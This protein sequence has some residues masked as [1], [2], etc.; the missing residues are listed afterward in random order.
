MAAQGS[1]HSDGPQRG[2]VARTVDLLRLIAESAGNASG[3]ELAEAAQLP[4]PSVHRLLALLIE[5]GMV[6]QDPTTKRYAP[7]IEF[8]RQAALVLRDRDIAE[9]ARP[10][11]ERLVGE[12]EEA[13][14]LGQYIG[15]GRMMFVGEVPS[16]DPLGYRIEKYVPTSVAWGASGRSI[17]AQLDDGTIGTVVRR[18]DRAPSTAAAM[19]SRKKMLEDLEEIRE[20]GYAFTI[21]GHKIA[22]SVG[23]AAPIFG[24]DRGV[25][26]SLCLTIPALRF[27][28]GSERRLGGL[29]V[30][31]AAELS[32]SL[33]HREWAIAGAGRTRS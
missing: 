24:R 32:D 26:G 18:G 21:D 6:V 1:T 19:P 11:L 2:T 25:M 12:S 33:S 15:A 4:G 29:I 10:F 13:C 3:K 9:I 30:A 31:S 27:K 16:R 22:N 7:G 8:S 28:R 23:I 20:R 17:L 14:L 5:Q